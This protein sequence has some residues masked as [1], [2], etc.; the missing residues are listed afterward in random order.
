MLRNAF[1]KALFESVDNT[2][3]IS[4]VGETRDKTFLEKVFGTGDD[5]KQKKE[6]RKKERKLKKKNKQDKKDN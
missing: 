6:D 3:S 4:T 1:V 2:V 5:R